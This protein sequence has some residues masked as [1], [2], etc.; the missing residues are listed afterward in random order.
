MFP[1]S[2][3][4]IIRGTAPVVRL[5]RRDAVESKKRMIEG[6]VELLGETK[7]AARISGEAENR[8]GRVVGHDNEAEH[9]V[10]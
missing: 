6:L 5:V 9:R 2:K 8:S 3:K 7:C 4:A 10:N 1:D